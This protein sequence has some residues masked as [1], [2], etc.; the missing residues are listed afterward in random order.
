MRRQVLLLRFEPEATPV[1]GDMPGFDVTSGPGTIT[2]VD[3]DGSTVPTAASY[4]T[5]VAMTGET[6]FVEDGEIAFDGGGLRVRTVG[7]GVME[8]S[9]EDGTLR[10]AVTWE[11]EGSGRLTGATG[12]VT[13]NFELAPERGTAAEQ[14]VVRLFLP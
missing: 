3:G 2:L 5:H 1:D 10:G 8:P 4:T 11:V 12:L 7:A 13:S 9:A 14:Q 6:T